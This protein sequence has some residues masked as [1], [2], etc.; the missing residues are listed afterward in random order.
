MR[1]NQVG[2]REFITLLGGVAAAWPLAVRAQQPDRIR[3]IG[4]LMVNAN[5]PNGQVLA[6]ELRNGLE[7]LG[8]IEGRNVQLEFRWTN[9]QPDLIRKYTAELVEMKPDVIVP[10][11]TANVIA[12]RMATQTIPIVFVMVSDPVRMGHVASMSHPGGNVTG[13]TPFEP[14]LGGKWVELLKEIF[15]TLTRVAVVFNPDTAANA[16]SFVEP[17]EVA[18][19]SLA[20]S[21]KSA[22]VRSEIELER[23][24]SEFAQPAS[25][26][27]AIPD[28]FTLARIELIVAATARH[29]LPLVTPFREFTARGAVL[30]YGINQADEF[31]RVATYIDRVLRGEKPSDLPVQAPGM[32]RPLLK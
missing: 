1:F 20:V 18:G 19:S 17:A 13:L 7:K 4:I 30:S 28:P 11:G 3:R 25:G 24:I 2:R 22:P 9:G 5:E 23:T 12:A 21:V 16:Q 10:H 29:R 14:S 32:S 6:R 26:L 31:R 27:I 8:W 15:P